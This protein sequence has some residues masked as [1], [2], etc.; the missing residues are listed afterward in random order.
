MG[1]EHLMTEERA[2]G[3]RVLT[4]N[5]PDR[6]NA[7][8]SRMRSEMRDAVEDAAGDPQ[9]RVLVLTGAGR[10][11]SA[12]EDVGEMGDLT[13]M[14]TRGFR[15]L[16]RGIHDVFDTVEAMEAPV[17]AAVEGVAA[18]GGFELALSCDF[19]V[20]GESARFVMPEA[21]VG[22]IPGSGGCSRLVRHVGLGRAKELVML[23]G[24][25]RAPRALELGL[26]TEVVADG[27]ALEAAVAMAG[28]LATMAPLALG[29]A[30]LVLNT[31]TDVDAETGRRLERLGQSVL[32]TTE[33]HR[34]G[35][36]AFLEKRPP[37]WLGR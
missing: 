2:G 18:G 37:Q 17:I 4:L 6:L 9:V 13:A 16:A 32:K 14:G 12:G 34:E 33:D 22:L 15:A 3:V 25:L 29:M 30:K 20:A 1:Y 26:A 35:A 23:G 21:K 10:G 24:T 7:W 28:R 11:F 19:R 36:R 5:R 27:G 31:C 8:N